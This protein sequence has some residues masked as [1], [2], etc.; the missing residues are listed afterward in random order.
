MPRVASCPQCEHELLVPEGANADAWATCPECKA[1]FELKG[2]VSRELPAL[3]LDD[4]YSAGTV[5]QSASTVPEFPP[6]GTS[7][8]DLTLPPI[9]IATTDTAANQCTERV[10]VV[11]FSEEHL[12]TES[13]TQD[14][15]EVAAERIDAWFRSAKTLS[16]LP[17]VVIPSPEPSD[18][19]VVESRAATPADISMALDPDVD[20]TGPETH[21]S[22]FE[23]EFSPELPAETAAWDDSQHMERLLAD[24]ENQPVDSFE[25][26]SPDAT[27]PPEEQPFPPD[28]QWRDEVPMTVPVGADAPR[29]KRSIVRAMVLTVFGGLIGLGLGYYV[30]L[31]VGAFL[32]RGPEI[33]FL[34]A[35]KYLPKAVLPASLRAGENATAA[36]PHSTNMIADLN[37]STKGTDSSPIAT[38]MPPEKK[39]SPEK[40]AAFTVPAELP[41]TKANPLSDDR[42]G[43]TTSKTAASPREPAKL[44]TPPAAPLT[45]ANATKPE[46]IRIADA[47]SFTSDQLT[48]ALQAAK[49]ALPKLV[50]GNLTDGRD[51]AHAKGTSY[52]TIADLAQK[53]TFVQPAASPEAKRL[54]LQ[55]DE[56][57]RTAL[58]NVHTREEVAQITPKW[59]SHSPRPQNGV[60]FAGMITRHEHKGNVDEYS[61]DLGGGQSLTVLA[62]SPAGSEITDS[63]RPVAVAGW[64]VEKPREQLA[65]YTGSTAEAVFAQRLIPLPQ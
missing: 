8:D 41:K 11:Q 54:H 52:M 25:H 27:V 39:A 5:A 17:Q 53:A 33:D 32:H 46:P 57:F 22:D 6:L 65:G 42:Y 48:A 56:F 24:L 44:D 9:E 60:F 51:V 21:H 19:S 43:T 26:N 14:S 18:E 64:I 55:V 36:A 47:P 7:R 37:A 40:Q 28:T 10:P 29:P 62:S 3:L 38:T 16:D 45:E 20:E 34:D 2:A 30:L 59:L 35:A 49:D 12:A 63:S 23:L 31:W 58:S 61:I 4:S 1:F 15:P 50:V 13:I